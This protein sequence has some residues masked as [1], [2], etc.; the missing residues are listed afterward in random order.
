MNFGK[1]EIL[2]WMPRS[3]LWSKGV[4]PNRREPEFKFWNFGM[5]EL[6]YFAA[7][8]K[9]KVCKRCGQNMPASRDLNK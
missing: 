1:W 8:N 5:I 9:K 7:F 3:W 4:Y 6:R 2:F